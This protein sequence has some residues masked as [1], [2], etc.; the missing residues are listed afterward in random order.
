[1]NLILLGLLFCCIAYGQSDKPKLY[2]PE[3]DA[4]KELAEAIK[5]AGQEGKYVLLQIGGNWCPWCIRFHKFINA[6]SSIDSIIKKDYIF[7]LVNHSKEKTEYKNMELLKQL[8]YPQRF[9]FPVLVVLDGSGKRLHT[10]DSGYLESGEG[11][12]KKK[13]ILFLKNWSPNALNPKNYTK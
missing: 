5:K 13:V 6:E 3:A 4:K 10:Q 1:M 2:N 9:G 12:D 7:L 8:D 11:Y